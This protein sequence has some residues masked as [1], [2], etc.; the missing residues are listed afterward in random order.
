M[1][2]KTTNANPSKPMN[3]TNASLLKFFSPIQKEPKKE[4]KESE[5]YIK[6]FL[7]KMRSEL[8]KKRGIKNVVSIKKLMQQSQ[9]SE[10]GKIWMKLLQFCDNCRPAYYGTWTK[11]SQKISPRNPF[12]KDTDILNYDYDS[13]DDDW[14]VPNGYLSEDERMLDSDGSVLSSSSLPVKSVGNEKN[15]NKPKIFEI[16]RPIVIGPIFEEY[17]GD[18]SHHQLVEY[19]AKLLNVDI[20]TSYN[21]FT[22]PP[23]IQHNHSTTKSTGQN[24]RKI[25]DQ[26]S[27]SSSSDWM[28][29]GAIPLLILPLNF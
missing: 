27:T 5:K 16:L 11:A 1:P 23:S 10:K 2:R 7:S 21:V 22:K 29:D 4:A 14:I 12:V 9:P 3:M 19:S 24:K 25:K 18:N 15:E 6:E 20:S 26:S 13:D 8:L 17:L 28:R